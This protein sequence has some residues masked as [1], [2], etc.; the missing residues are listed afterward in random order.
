LPRCGRYALS[1]K[2][3]A[4]QGFWEGSDGG[5]YERRRERSRRKQSEQARKGRDVGPLP[6]PVDPIRREACRRNLRL[7]C[8][9]YGG[10]TFALEWSEDHLRVI[11]KLEATILYG[12]QY[13]LAMP[14]GTGKTSLVVWATIWAVAY[15]HRQF[16]VAVGATK[17]LAET[18]LDAIKASIE[19]NE[20]LAGD[21]PE[22][23]HPIRMLD[24]INNRSAGQLLDG[25]RTRIKWTGSRLVFPT[26]EGADSSGV[27]VHACGLL[28]SLRGLQFTRA[29]GS[30]VRPG[31]VLLDDPQTDESARRPAQTATRLKIVKQAV[32]GL[33]G[34]GQKIAVVC[35]CTVIAPNDMADQ[36]LNLE[37]SPE[38]Q[39]ERTQ[40]IYD[41]PARLDLWDTYAEKRGD[42]LRDRGD[43]SAATEFYKD[44]REEMA[45]G[46]RVAWPQRFNHDQIDAIQYA[47][48]LRAKDE[49]SFLAEYQNNP[50][51]IQD[52]G[53]DS[54][55]AAEL[56]ARRNGLPFRHVPDGHSKLTAFIDVQQ[57]VLPW[58]VCAWSDDMAGAVIDHGVWPEQ[59]KRYWT[60]RDLRATLRS[61]T[62]HSTVE[63]ALSEGLAELTT[64]LLE[65]RYG[66]L[67]IQWLGIDANW[68]LSTELVYQFCRSFG[69]G[70][71]VY[72][73][74]GR[75]IGAASLPMSKW[76]NK[77]G[78]RDGHFWRVELGKR[79]Q[80]HV[81]TDANA[82]KSIVM[83]RLRVEQN[84]GGGIW[85]NGED[86]RYL[87]CLAD[88]LSAE[89]C[90][91]I[92]G[93]GRRVDEWKNRPG[94]DNH[95]FDCLVGCA[96]GASML[97][98]TIP[99][100]V[101]TAK[102]AAMDL[103]EMQ[104][105]ARARDGRR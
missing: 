77:P 57:D 50:K 26:V 1:K 87:E 9:T 44:N 11:A 68:G 30:T 75:F 70:G 4:Q 103:A 99:G 78:E 88:Q 55:N 105:R 97:G 47:M 22:I 34:P 102:P 27:V 23:A 10:G 52:A 60:L 66:G 61:K 69:S 15:G 67:Q 35:P 62:G 43:I 85:F 21:F 93:R 13:A 100:Q 45:R 72:P 39:G 59:G 79:R 63:G 32:L 71:I 64:D 98:A 40:L 29:D 74:H 42:S 49:E 90:V 73:H 86:P 56:L 101:S 41:L 31:L 84:R 38:W 37:L 104:R 2:R 91:A 7:F 6:K 58:L 53:I 96:V 81:I 95:Y 46:A 25:V 36:L 28:G 51:P 5:D 89:F 14:R 92:T 83:R 3:M 80:R 16:I 8:E 54:L 33:A 76:K 94:R 48:D 17:P 18:M 12:G 82:W 65:R 20:T 19:T 24:G